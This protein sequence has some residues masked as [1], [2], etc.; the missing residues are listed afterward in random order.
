[1]KVCTLLSARLTE[2]DAE[3]PCLTA[4]RSPC[5]LPWLTRAGIDNRTSSMADGVNRLAIGNSV[6]R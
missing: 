1:M 2:L 3:L 4:V 5:K 6:S